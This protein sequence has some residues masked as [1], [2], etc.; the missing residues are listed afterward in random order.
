YLRWHYTN[1]L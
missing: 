1:K